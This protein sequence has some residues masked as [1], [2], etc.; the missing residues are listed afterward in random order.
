MNY[1]NWNQIWIV[2]TLSQLIWHQKEFRLVP[3][4]FSLRNTVITVQIWFY[5]YQD[6]EKIWYWNFLG[7]LRG[8]LAVYAPTEKYFRNIIKSNLNHIVFTIFP[9]IWSSSVR[10]LF[11]I[12]R[13]MVNT[14]WFWFDLITFRK[15][16]SVCPC[17]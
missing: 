8:L 10:F 12:N 16:F 14:I 1:V 15:D 5:I 2:I 9:L 4:Q 11:Q 13:C 17:W 6:C 3:D 7:E